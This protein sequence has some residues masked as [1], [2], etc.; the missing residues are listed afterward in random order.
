ML[1]WSNNIET[2]AAALIFGPESR[3]NA[4]RYEG[5]VSV[6]YPANPR[7]IIKKLKLKKG[8]AVAPPVAFFSPFFYFFSS[9]RI[10]KQIKGFDNC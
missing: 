4:V 10:F 8:K 7:D 1:S 5:L 9:F 3:A 2:A 6:V